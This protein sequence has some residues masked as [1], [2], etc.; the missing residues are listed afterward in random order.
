M[1]K[2]NPCCGEIWAIDDAEIRW[3][4]DNSTLGKEGKERFVLITTNQVYIERNNPKYILVIPIT[5]KASHQWDYKLE[6]AEHPYSNLSSTSTLR[7]MMIQPIPKNI[8]QRRVGRLEEDV[9]REILV[10]IIDN[11]GLE[12]VKD[13]EKEDPWKNFFQAPSN[14][15]K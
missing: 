14:R 11:F 8:L 5:S 1:P 13:E 15:E 7:L 2:N 9:L 10:K 6:R 3:I 12:Y 4:D